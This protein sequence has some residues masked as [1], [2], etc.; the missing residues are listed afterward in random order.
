MRVSLVAGASNPL[1]ENN[2]GPDMPGLRVAA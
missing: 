2:E 1:A